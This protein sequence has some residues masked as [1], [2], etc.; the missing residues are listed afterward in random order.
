M[1]WK[2]FSSQQKERGFTLVEILVA[3]V[4]LLLV[5]TACFPLFTLAA[6]IT[7]ENR[8]RIT[9]GE[10]AKKEIERTLSAVTSGNYIDEDANAPLRTT[11]SES[12]VD[13]TGYPGYKIKKTVEWVD[14]PDD[15]IHPVDRIPYDYKL[16]SV[17][18]IYPSLFSGSVIRKADFKTSVAR[19]GTASP[20]T[21]LVVEVVEL[22]D[23]L[24]TNEQVIGATVTITN[25]DTG[26]EDFA[27]T[28]E[29]G[30]AFFQI[31]VPETVPEYTYEVLVEADGLIMD[32]SPAHLN[33]ATLTRETSSSITIA[34]AK[35]SSI[36]VRF[37]S[38]KAPGYLEVVGGSYG[39]SQDITPADLNDSTITRTFDDLWPFTAYQ[40]N[41]YLSIHKTDFTDDTVLA[42][43]EE[44]PPD[45]DKTNIWTY[46]DIPDELGWVARPGDYGSE[47]E[48][49]D[50]HSLKYLL[51]LS[52]YSPGAPSVQVLALTMDPFTEF[53]VD[54]GSENGSYAVLQMNEEPDA[55]D[56]NEVDDWTPIIS[57]SDL[58]AVCAG[59]D[60]VIPLPLRPQVILSD[61]F[62][63]RFESTPNIT[64]LVI[65]D[66][67]ITCH[68]Q[69]NV[70]FS[71]PDEKYILNLTN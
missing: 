15:G 71:S 52:N 14:D 68:Y 36:R 10:L 51:D 35:P 38:P 70:T 20:T 56:L 33:R 25:L 22:L 1:S 39:E 6:K 46:S 3:L 58:I 16:L 48:F 7:H 67:Y 63:L 21:G 4:I 26:D 32:P 47:V 53:S 55:H 49:A 54:Q 42:S 57:L 69:G 27:T 9:A 59:A 50:N 19:E 62:A 5:V 61:N 24:P 37:Q 41:A 18:V 30:F 13:I 23:S 17:E 29:A 45:G 11:G 31:E 60:P 44:S 12:F 34:T 64:G 65:R 40:I 2:G 28:N 43:F 8:M 66:F